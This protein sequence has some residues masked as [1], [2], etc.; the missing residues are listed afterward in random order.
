M[1]QY[2]KLTPQELSRFNNLRPVQNEA[3]MFWA[4]VAKARGLDPASL[5]GDENGRSFSGL[6]LGHGLHWCAPYPLT[7]KHKP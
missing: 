1:R 2:H 3:L 7:C 5:I 6:P 4:T